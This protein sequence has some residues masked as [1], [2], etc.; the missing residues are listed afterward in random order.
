LNRLANKFKSDKG[1]LYYNRHFY[2]RVYDYYLSA[3][4]SEE[5]TL[6]EIGLLRHDVQA[7]GTGG[8]CNEAPS[9]SMWSEYFPQAQIHGVDIVSFAN[10]ETDRITFTQADQ[11]DRA[12]LAQVIN[13]SRYPIKVMVDDGSHASHHQQI[14]LAALF[15]HL[16]SGGLYFIEDLHYQPPQWEV[17][18]AIKTKRWLQ[19]IGEGRP[20]RSSFIDEN[21]MAYLLANIEDI[22]FYDSLDYAASSLGQD[23]L[24]VIRKR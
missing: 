11:A 13:R 15:P 21:E 4:R 1:D 8:P 18:E 14:S 24:A 20:L 23:S 19:S 7:A 22:Q 9:L 6:L 17:P 10:I 16:A 2:S 12:G 5:M 3:L